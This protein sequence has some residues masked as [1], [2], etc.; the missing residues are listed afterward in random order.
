MTIGGKYK[1]K[2]DVNPGPGQY[3]ADASVMHTLPKSRSAVMRPDTSPYRRPKE[4]LPD[5]G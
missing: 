1:W 3:D 2:A 4:S 5:P